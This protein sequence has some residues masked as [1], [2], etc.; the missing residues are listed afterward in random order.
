MILS[1]EVHIQVVVNCCGCVL[2]VAATVWRNVMTAGE[3]NLEASGNAPDHAR[4]SGR[5]LIPDFE[6]MRAPRDPP[7]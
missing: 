2:G 3:V 6:D 5:Y 1:A 4:V 7:I